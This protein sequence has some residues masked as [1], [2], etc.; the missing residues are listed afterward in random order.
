MLFH[1]ARDYKISQVAIGL[2][3]YTKTLSTFIQLLC[4]WI[5]SFVLFLLTPNIP[6]TGFRLCLQ[7]EPTQMS[8]I[9]R[10]S[11]YLRTLAPTQDRVHKGSTVQAICKS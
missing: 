1:Q 2:I 5:L 10:A 6:E 3:S 9:D 7:V 4:F 11:P 8:P